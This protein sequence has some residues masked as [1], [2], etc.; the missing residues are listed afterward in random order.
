VTEDE[1]D[2]QGAS[3][4]TEPDD[5][6]ASSDPEKSEGRR[7]FRAATEDE[8]DPQS[9]MVSDGRSA[10]RA[11]LRGGSIAH[12]RGD[13]HFIGGVVRR[14][15]EALR[16]G[17]EVYRAGTGF[18]SNAQL[19]N[20]EFGHSVVVELE[21]SPEEDVQLGIEGE[22][23]SPTIDAAHALGQMLSA[24]PGELIP[25]ALKLGP[26]ATAAY[27]RMLNILAGDEVTMEWQVPDQGK[28]AVVS[29]ADAR[30]DFAILDREGEQRVE[31]VAVPGKLTM[32]DSELRQFAL[33][34]PSKLARPPLL[35]SK[36]RV[37]GTYPE[38]IGA[39]LKSQ[40]LWDTDV[41]ATIEVTF[42]VPGTTPIPR[43][44]TYVL[45]DAEPLVSASPS[46]FE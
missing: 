35:K 42:D 16:Q 9:F 43:D 39:R 4:S 14:L 13:A 45:A 8:L 40:G 10:L 1:D 31:S 30:H 21:I 15:A 27:K 34:L 29:S 18:I 41:M 32:A 6:E 7:R 44:P 12:N 33:T 23:H 28:I 11:V 25:R 24:N 5:N 22:R 2:K 37:R 36:H 3:E 46:L 26:D 17:A 19:R 20:L 38:D